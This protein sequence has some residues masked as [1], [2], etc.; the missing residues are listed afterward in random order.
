[1]PPARRFAALAAVAACLLGNGASAES[2][3]LLDAVR[4]TLTKNPDIQLQEKQVEFS[5]G[6][7]QQATG[8]FDRAV[9]LTAGRTTDNSPLNQNDR[10]SFAAQGFALSQL[11]TDTTTYNLALDQPLRNGVVLSPSVSATRTEGSNSDI[12][13]LP[14]QN[15]GV[16]S[17]SIRVPLWRGSGESAAAFENAA[18]LDWEASKQDLRFSVAQSVLGTVSAYWNLLAARKNLDIALE[19]EASIR[20]LV[21]ET[22]KLIEADELPAAD[23]NLIRANLLDKTAA[24]IAAEQA[25]LDARQKLG[26]AMGLPYPQITTLEPADGFPS[27]A[28]ELPALENERLIELAMKRR[29]DLTAARLRQD[30]AKILAS[31]AQ[32]NLRPQL[33]LNFGLGYAGLAEGSSA[34]NLASALGQHRGGANI[35]ASISYQWPFDNNVA[36]GRF[37]QQSALYDQGTI[38]IRELARVISINVETTLAGLARSARQLGESEQSVELYRITVEN[39]KTKHRLGNATL[40]D[41]LS[42]ND[43]LLN[44]R[45]G[46]ISFRLNYLTAIARLNF[47]TGMLLAEDKS[48]QSIR[49]DQ[50]LGVPKFD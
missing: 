46:N 22:R 49:L 18:N 16:V 30:S 45:L 33:D 41:V 50:L 5:Q 24:R 29:A 14:P 43:R 25:L 48:G 27:L 3:S 6:A 32:N 35:G 44:A 8:Q 1:M 21:A 28:T 2:V 37:L 13:N 19:A 42:V 10:N 11:R 26:Q 7:L 34:A 12:F 17:F 31:A 36:R 15:R 9:R 20:Q 47:E 40:I 39:E 23:L 38:R 4:L